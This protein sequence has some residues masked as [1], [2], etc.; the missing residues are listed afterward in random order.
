M[1]SNFGE[2]QIESKLDLSTIDLQL[3]AITAVYIYVGTALSA[4]NGAGAV[5]CDSRRAIGPTKTIRG[6]I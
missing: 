1:L 5:D 4:N 2:L 6:Y 3:Y